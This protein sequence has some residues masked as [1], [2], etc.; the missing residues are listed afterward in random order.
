MLLFLTLPDVFPK[1]CPSVHDLGNRMTNPNQLIVIFH[2]LIIPAEKIAQ[3]EAV[4]KPSFSIWWCH[5]VVDDSPQTL[6]AQGAWK[7]LPHFSDTTF[8]SSSAASEQGRFPRVSVAQRQIRQENKRIR[9]AVLRVFQTVE[10]MAF[11]INVADEIIPVRYVSV[12]SFSPVSAQ[13]A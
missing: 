1:R 6:A 5:G 4:L 9:L 13:F 7:R 10:L 12:R 8:Q 3:K 11:I 2:R